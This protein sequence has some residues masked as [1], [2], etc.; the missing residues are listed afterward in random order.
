M[1]QVVACWIA[2]LIVK[3]SILLWGKFHPIFI[4]LVLAVSGPIQPAQCKTSGLKHCSLYFISIDFGI[5]VTL[6]LLLPAIF[7]EL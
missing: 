4:S 6:D 7:A 2:E 3:Q 1:V 5:Y